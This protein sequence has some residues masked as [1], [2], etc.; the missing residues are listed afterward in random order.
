MD[1][2]K[3]RKLNDKDND[4][5]DH[6]HRT[7]EAMVD[8]SKLQE[9]KNGDI[10]AGVYL[11]KKKLSQLASNL[12][13]AMTNN[14]S[15]LIKKPL[16]EDRL[17]QP[18]DLSA[19]NPNTINTINITNTS[20]T[21]QRPQK[22]QVFPKANPYET[23]NEKQLEKITE[24]HLHTFSSQVRE[25]SEN[26]ERELK[27]RGIFCV[28]SL[29][30]FLDED[31]ILMSRKQRAVELIV[32]ILIENKL[33]KELK[34]KIVKLYSEMVLPSLKEL[35]DEDLKEYAKDKISRIENVLEDMKM[36]AKETR[37]SRA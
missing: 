36:P 29:V 3:L 17:S 27:N 33:D 34:D 25:V 21:R 11:G 7:I 13:T 6:V 26:G 20:N 35:H 19:D 16:I 37:P 23:L 14:M 28:K 30:L 2:S 8:K 12:K 4:H 18:I 22:P 15:G 32:D 10:G 5:E 24:K 1:S 31:K 9:L